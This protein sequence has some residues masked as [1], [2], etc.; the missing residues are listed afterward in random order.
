MK[1]I[2]YIIAA[3][4]LSLPLSSCVKDDLYNTGQSEKPVAVLLIVV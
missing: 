4:A 1:A 2:Q 3:A